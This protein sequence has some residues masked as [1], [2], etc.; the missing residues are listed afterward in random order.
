MLG[1]TPAEAE[2]EHQEQDKEKEGRGGG[3]RSHSGTSWTCPDKRIG[4][5]VGKSSPMEV[6]S[7]K[8]HE[9]ASRED[10]HALRGERQR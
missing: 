6:N 10:L 9:S 7:M 5:Q 2:E 1:P 8:R 4:Q 3:D